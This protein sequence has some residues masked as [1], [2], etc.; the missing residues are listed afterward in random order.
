MATCV[1]IACVSHRATIPP[2]ASLALS[3]DAARLTQGFI[4]AS[5]LLSSRLSLALDETPL[6]LH[7]LLLP[8]TDRRASLSARTPHTRARTLSLK[9]S[10]AFPP[11]SQRALPP[12]RRLTD[13]LAVWTHQALSPNVFTQQ[14]CVLPYCCRVSPFL[15]L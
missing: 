14:R 2:G 10:Q 8:R 7:S 15:F 5:A 1:H 12:L 6:A 13:V 11:S 4:H 9:R 3:A